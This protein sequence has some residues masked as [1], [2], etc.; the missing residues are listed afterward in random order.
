MKKLSS[1]YVILIVV[2]GSITITTVLADTV[3]IGTYPY[4]IQDGLSNQQLV[5]TSSGNVGIG[6]TL[7]SG[8]LQ[9]NTPGGTYLNMSASGIEIGSIV[10]PTATNDIRF[11]SFGNLLLFPAQHQSGNVGIGISNPSSKLQIDISGGTYLNMSA[12]GIEIGSLARPGGT[13]DMRFNSYNN[14]L[15]M[16]AQVASSGNVGIG[17]TS[18]VQKLEVNG[19]IQSDGNLTTSST[20]KEFKITSPSGVPICIGTGC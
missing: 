16:P 18:P 6:T 7:P 11:N 13:N 17:T 12:S 8:K 15:L 9:V 3:T 19:N 1:S 20:N 2:L 5:I 14:I 4:T 10:R